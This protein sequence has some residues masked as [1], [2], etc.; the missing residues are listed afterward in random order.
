MPLRVGYG[1]GAGE[2]SNGGET[3]SNKPGSVNKYLIFHY[4]ANDKP[5]HR[6]AELIDDTCCC[7]AVF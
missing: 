4:Q 7:I 6:P 5:F 2:T 1:A 3:K